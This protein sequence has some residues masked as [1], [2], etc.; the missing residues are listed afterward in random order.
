MNGHPQR[1]GLSIALVALL[2]GCGSAP[3]LPPVAV[4]GSA[5][6]LTALAGRW[7]GQ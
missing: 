7:S 1:I 4:Y 6:D 3:P 5:A 2:A